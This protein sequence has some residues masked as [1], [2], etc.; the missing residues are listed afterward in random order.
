MSSWTR[1]K[2]CII[3]E[4]SAIGT[5]ISAEPPRLSHASR[6]STGLMRLPLLF[7]SAM[8]SPIE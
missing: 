5:A 4:A 7:L 1:R 2:L 3:S 8:S 6:H